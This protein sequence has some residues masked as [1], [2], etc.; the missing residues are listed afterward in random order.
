MQ[1]GIWYTT[2]GTSYPLLL[3]T[4]S[5]KI[6]NYV[7]K[8]IEHLEATDELPERWRWKECKVSKANWEIYSRVMDHETALDDVYAALTELADIIA[9]E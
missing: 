2:E 6:Y 3:D 9:G 8:D 4:G 1:E 5:S 7:R